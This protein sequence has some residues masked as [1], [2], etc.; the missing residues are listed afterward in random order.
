[1][2]VVSYIY[3]TPKVRSLGLVG[4]EL[5]SGW[6]LNGITHIQ[7]GT[8]FNITSGADSNFDGTTNDRPNVVG[9]PYIGGGRSRAQKIAQYFNTA[10]FATPG[11]GQPYGNAQFDLLFGPRYVDT[12]LSAFKTFSIY[13]ETNLQFRAEAFNVFN[14]VNLSNPASNLATPATFG[15]ISGTNAARIFQFALRLSY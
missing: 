2:F 11:T 12:D 8:P 5:L 15:Q 14:N 7:S 3:V 1:V 9:I 13:K 6:Q 4:K 10:A